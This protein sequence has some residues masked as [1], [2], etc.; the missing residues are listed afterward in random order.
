MRNSLSKCAGCKSIISLINNKYSMTS[1]KGIIIKICSKCYKCNVMCYNDIHHN[2]EYIGCEVDTTY[3]V[4]RDRY[5]IYN[6]ILKYAADKCVK[7]D[8]Y[9]YLIELFDKYFPRPILMEIMKYYYYSDELHL[10]FIKNFNKQLLYHCH[11]CDKK[12]KLTQ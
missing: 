6:I 1:T 3:T 4:S 7:N 11:M 9:D 8:I 10:W 5:V 2:T 12:Y